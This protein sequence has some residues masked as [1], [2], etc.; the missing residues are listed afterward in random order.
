MKVGDL[1]K[2]KHDV[3]RGSGIVLAVSPPDRMTNHERADA[4][5]TSHGLTRKVTVTTMY[6]EVIGHE[7]R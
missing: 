7:S 6:M 4:L 5:W 3:M 1:I 2:H